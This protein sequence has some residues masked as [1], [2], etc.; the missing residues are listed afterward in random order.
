ML[1]RKSGHSLS[2]E[3]NYDT[4]SN[5]ATKSFAWVGVEGCE[6][7]FL[8]DFRWSAQ[9]IPWHDLLLLLEGKIVR[10]PAPKTHYAQDIVFE[11]D[12]PIFCTANEHFSFVRGG[13]VDRVETEMMRVRWRCFHFFSQIPQDQQ[14]SIPSCPRCFTEFILH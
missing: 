4:F 8:N 2:I 3:C 9:I 1:K 14:I 6:V 7:I 13:A 11:K 10:F 12:S 5:P